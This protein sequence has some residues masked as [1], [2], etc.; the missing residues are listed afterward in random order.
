MSHGCHP[1]CW[2]HSAMSPYLRGPTRQHSMPG[3]CLLSL[4]LPPG[5]QEI[6][7]KVLV[8]PRAPA[9]GSFC[10][11]EVG[12][13]GRREPPVSPG[14]APGQPEV[15]DETVRP[16]GAL[17]PEGWP[18]RCPF[19]Q[20]CESPAWTT[21]RVT[22]AHTRS[23]PVGVGRSAWVLSHQCQFC[24]LVVGLVSSGPTRAGGGQ[25]CHL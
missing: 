3:H 12:A 7:E 10:S 6:P 16:C 14:A 11:S 8:V 25:A 24:L 1:P 2:S 15:L 21:R 19:R 20:V 13:A 9:R 22:P 5:S 23:G 4:R 18:V 17:G